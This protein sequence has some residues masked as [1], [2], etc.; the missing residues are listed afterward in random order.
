MVDEPD[1]L[2]LRYHADQ[3]GIVGRHG[4]GGLVMGRVEPLPVRSDRDDAHLGEPASS[5]V[6]TPVLR[7]RSSA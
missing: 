1:R 2:G 4:A 3:L 5:W 6:A 7:A